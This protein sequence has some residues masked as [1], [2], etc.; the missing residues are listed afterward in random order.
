MKWRLLPALA[1]LVLLPLGAL[2][3]LGF[4][5]A[6]DEYERLDSTYRNLVRASLAEFDRRIAGLLEERRLEFR[7]LTASEAWT[8]E[9]YRHLPRTHPLLAH[10]F[11]QGGDGQVLAPSPGTPLSEDEHGFLVR[12]QALFDQKVLLIP[13]SEQS[14]PPADV[15]VTPREAVVTDGWHAWYWDQDIHL[16]YW[17]RTADGGVIGVE[18]ARTR[19][20]A[21]IIGILPDAAEAASAPMPGS[22]AVVLSDS[23]NRPLYRWGPQAG[24]ARL[25]LSMPLAPP[26]HSW[27]LQAFAPP[28]FP[29]RGFQAGLRLQI[30][31][32]LLAVGLTLTGLAVYLYREHARDLLEAQQRVSFVNQVS[33]ELKT[34]LTN[35]RMFAELLAESLPDDDPESRKRL[36]II[37]LE[38]RRL[39]R[40]IGNVLTFSRHRSGRLH[41][42]P[43]LE[44]PDQVLSGVVDGFR[45]ALAAKGIDVQLDVG[46]S[47]EFSFDADLLGQI[48]GNLLS[49][50]EKY[51]AGGKRCLVACRTVDRELL[52]LVRD[53]GP[54]IPRDKLE[55]VFQPFTRL[56]D[57]LNE[58]V[59]GTGIGLSISRDLARLHGGDIG[60]LYSNGPVEEAAPDGLPGGLPAHEPGQG[61]CFLVRLAWRDAISGGEA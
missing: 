57:A 9:E 61:A 2:S 36:D 31:A 54:G 26:F 5:A 49:N 47:A 46:T 20:L 7:R 28:G 10:C 18:P 40:M 15:R 33:H 44:A 24:N 3:W 13:Q 25:L 56:S 38:S 34:P 37:I 55:T 27:T 1:A 23:L 14:G 32:G 60:I 51:A 42:R 22:A 21:D 59:S 12:T 53:F 41:A 35:I 43:R 11:A 48:V 29:G 50:V 4:R 30:L 45:P 16:L 17:R 19:L 6:G 39:S 8:D 58:G 52:V